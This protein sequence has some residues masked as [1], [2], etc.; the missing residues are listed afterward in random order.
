MVTQP[1]YG[2]VK[3]TLLNGAPIRDLIPKHSTQ[4]VDPHVMPDVDVAGVLRDDSLQ[5]RQISRYGVGIVTNLTQADGEMRYRGDE[6]IWKMAIYSREAVSLNVQMSNLQL[7]QGAQMFI[8]NADETMVVGPVEAGNVH[9]NRLATT[10]IKGNEVIFEVIM[11]AE[12]A[13]QFTVTVHGVTHGFGRRGVVE[14]GFGDSGTCTVDVNCSTANANT[15]SR[16][17]VVRII[18]PTIF[19]SGVLLNNSCHDMRAL[20]LSSLHTSDVGGNPSSWV[21]EFNYDSPNPTSPTCRGSEPSSVIAYDGATYRSGWNGTGF[22]LFE[23]SQSVYNQPTIALA[24]WDRTSTTTPSSGYGISHPAG[25]VKKITRENNSFF[26]TAFLGPIGSTP[27]DFWRVVWDLGAMGSLGVG[28][29]PIFD[30]NDRVVG[31]LA[32]LTSSCSNLGG[33]DYY[34]RFSSSWIGGGASNSGLNPWLGNGGSPLTVNSIRPV[35]A[36]TGPS[37]ICT[38]S[39]TNQTFT[40]PNKIPARTISWNVTP[41]NKF[42]TT[43]GASTSG[44]TA[45]AVIRPL[46]N[47]SGFATVTFTQPS[48]GGTCGPLVWS[49][50][51]WLGKPVGNLQMSSSTYCSGAFGSAE[52]QNIVGQGITSYT[53]VKTGPINSFNPQ[54]SYATFIAGPVGT[55]GAGA[56]LNVTA[57]NVCGSYSETEFVGI[58]PCLQNPNDPNSAMAQAPDAIV[59]TVSPNPAR[60]HVQV[61]WMQANNQAPSAGLYAYSLKD[62]YG[63]TLQTFESGDPY[64]SFE[65]ANLRTGI[66]YI[67]VVHDGQISRKS[68]AVSN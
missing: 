41:A 64:G 57:T 68:V 20:L 4:V 65:V 11:P 59:L 12:S 9:N 10:I 34:G 67:E 15:V 35:L 44:S 51:F 8:Y 26:A 14:R 19:A 55:G 61:S 22:A 24:G 40:L 21:F 60:H 36:M 13:E 53:W 33:P 52:L 58:V 43:S 39:P 48:P 16:D 17:A 2:Q 5:G 32:D 54:F 42:A 28:G 62:T 31:Q 37:I 47:A 18:T 56:S 63:R 45:T 50:T 27:A 66:Y 1:V 29:S 3:T 49:K 38:S 6:V 25:D 46:L 30:Q 23:L 7:P